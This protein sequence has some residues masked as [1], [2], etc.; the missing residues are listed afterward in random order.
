MKLELDAPGVK[1]AD[2]T[3]FMG[4]PREFRFG[5]LPCGEWRLTVKPGGK[6]R[7][8]DVSGDSARVVPC[9]G[10][11]ETRVVLVPVRR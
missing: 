3:L 11:T 1:P 10:A 7:Y 9:S 8:A 5:P 6:L 4:A 2:V